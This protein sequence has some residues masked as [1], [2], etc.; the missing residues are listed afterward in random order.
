MAN[1]PS[2]VVKSVNRW[3]PNPAPASN[4]KLS[5]YLFHELNRLSDVIFNIDVMR[6]EQT[7]QTVDKPRDGDIRYA[8]GTNWNPGQGQNLYYYDG[9]TWQAFAGGSG[10]GDYIQLV[11][12]TQQTCSAADTA[13]TLTWDSAPFS[14]GISLNSSDSSRIDFT[15]GGTYLGLVSF[16]LTSNSASSKE[17][18]LWPSI[19]G[20]DVGG[21]SGIHHALHEIN[22]RRTVSRGVMFRIGAGS[23]LQGKWAVDDTD[24]YIEPEPATSFA[25]A[26][27][28]ASL[29]IMQVSQDTT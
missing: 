25:P 19:D 26:C 7:N 24:L 17:I 29:T 18:W 23:Y 15:H 20:T 6:L 16:L 21:A 22:S 2:K 27:P 5:D 9:A 8:D 11:S 14:S 4:D 12:T 10:A 28:S 13:Q 3:T 1:A